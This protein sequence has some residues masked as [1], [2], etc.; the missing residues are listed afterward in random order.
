VR[1]HPLPTRDSFGGEF[2]VSGDLPRITALAAVMEPPEK[3]KH[4]PT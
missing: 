1:K 2:P 4:P 3:H